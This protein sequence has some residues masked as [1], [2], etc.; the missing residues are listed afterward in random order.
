MSHQPTGN[1]VLL[2]TVSG[3]DYAEVF[4]AAAA[5]FADPAQS[6]VVVWGLNLDEQGPLYGESDDLF[7][8][9]LFYQRFDRPRLVRET[10]E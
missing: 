5:W 7:Y 9:E 2:E 6:D 1:T 8:L 4:A 10:L 3:R